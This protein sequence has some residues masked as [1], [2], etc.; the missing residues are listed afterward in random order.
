M[1]KLPLKGPSDSVGVFSPENIYPLFMLLLLVVAIALAYDVVRPFFNTL[2]LATVLAIICA[3]VHARMTDLLWGKRGL[4][5]GVTVCV[6]MVAII[7][8]MSFFLFGLLGQGRESLTAL[9]VWVM[10]NDM[11]DYFRI[12]MLK[13]YLDW[14]QSHLPFI[15]LEGLNIEGQL[16][17]FTSE[18]T[19]NLV[20]FGRT[21]AGNAAMLVFHFIIMLG[22]LFYFVRDG[23]AIMARIKYLCPMRSEQ[24][25]LIIETL[26]RV[27]RSVLLGS[28]AVAVLQG[29][30]GGI[31]LAICGIP[32]F[33]WG[34]IMGMASLIP[35]VGTGL[36]WVP[37]CIYL[38]VSGQWGWAL[39]LALYSGIFVVGI[40][41]FLRPVLLQEA[42]NIPAF[43]IFLSILGGL[44]AFGPL[45][46]LYGPLVLC[47]VMVMLE[48]YGEEY[49]D[50]L[51]DASD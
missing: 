13:P 18:F 38:L 2:V 39:F 9:S 19:S 23:H 7:L 33:F 44:G 35:M 32:G 40:D 11:G 45:G 4:A 48:I 10:Q 6:A 29:V 43:F 46:L 42:S 22:L 37:A 47:F 34:T 3:P 26:K 25:E 15:H 17:S 51:N 50:V 30:A 31:G 14:M 20:R 12:D 8:P 28:L 5:A 41:T 27:S 24:E 16:L 1:D 36:V 49:K 21:L